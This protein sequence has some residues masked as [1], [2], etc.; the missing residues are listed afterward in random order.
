MTSAPPPAPP[1]APPVEPPGGQPP[2]APPPPPPPSPPPPPPP[3]AWSTRAPLRRSRS[4]KV[5]GGVAGGLAEYS[6]VDALLWRVGFVALAITG[7]FGLLAYILLW[8][9]M[10]AGPA[11]PYDPAAAPVKTRAGRPPRG[12]RSPIPGITIAALLIVLGVLTLLDRFAGRDIGSQVF[13][14]SALLVVGLGLVAAAFSTGRTAR[15]GLIALGVILSLALIGSS[16]VNWRDV[17]G[18]GDRTYR[19]ALASQVQPVYRGGIG[20]LTVDLSALDFANGDSPVRTRIDHGVGD[21]R[22]LVPTDADVQ[23]RV[24]HGLGDVTAFGESGVGDE[25]FAGNGP[26]SWSGDG[27]PEIVLNIHAGIGDVA[28]DR[29]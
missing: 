29:A 6:G 3:P 21:V 24:D 5:I 22:V 15:G 25:T 4:D 8:A 10:P 9:L 20:D 7:G 23:V 16:S 1:P 27:R 26:E 11:A 14:G 2:P 28:V 13:L 12:P 19:P 18:V 17:H